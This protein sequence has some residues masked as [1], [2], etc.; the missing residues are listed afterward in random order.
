MRLEP[1]LHDTKYKREY[2]SLAFLLALTG[3]FFVERS[4]DKEESAGLMAAENQKAL[5]FRAPEEGTYLPFLTKLFGKASAP[6]LAEALEESGATV[7]N[8]SESEGTIDEN[9]KF[10]KIRVQGTGSFAQIVRGFDIIKG[11]ERWNA[12]DLKS[13]KREGGQLSFD[14]EIRT[15]QSRGTYEKEKYS[16]DR[17][18][19]DRKEPRGEDSR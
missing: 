1:I 7:T 18:H 10:Q 2:L 15:F 17:S 19:G 14:A 11:K 8:I 5:H 6:E 16:S 12:M 13:L 3:C 9:G 4:W